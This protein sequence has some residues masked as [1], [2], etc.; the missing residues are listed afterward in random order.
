M[1]KKFR[2]VSDS[3]SGYEVQYKVWFWP[4]WIQCDMTN[5]SSTLQEAKEKLDYF[6]NRPKIYY[7]E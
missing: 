2:I 5:T 3:W 7:Q 1:K 6:K 4:F